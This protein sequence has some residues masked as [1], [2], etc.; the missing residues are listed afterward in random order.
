MKA[1]SPITSPAEC[2]SPS[3]RPSIWMSP[4]D[5]SVP[6]TTRSAEMIEGAEE[7]AARLAGG[8]LAG[9]GGGAATF[10]LENMAA[11]LDKGAR[12][13]HDVVVPDL[14]MDMRSGA[15]PGRSEFSDGRAFRHLRPDVNENRRHMAVSGMDSEAMVNFNHVSVAAPVARVHN[16]TWCRC[17]DERTPRAREID[18]RMEGIVSGKRIDTGAEAAGAL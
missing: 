5:V 11:C 18:A 12:I 17:R 14:I 8:T 7:R 16:R 10:L 1:L 2:T 4:V 9:T 3:M 13:A 15:A 6:L